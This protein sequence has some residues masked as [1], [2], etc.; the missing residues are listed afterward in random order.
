M[1][2]I[3]ADSR[4]RFWL[5]ALLALVLGSLLFRFTL[6]RF[7][8]TP[9][10][11]SLSNLTIIDAV[12]R[13]DWNAINAVPPDPLRLAEDLEDVLPQL[14]D[15]GSEIAAIL[16]SRY[17]S[18]HT[19]R[20]MLALTTS[21]HLQAAMS[22]AM[23]ISGLPHPPAVMD[24]AIT[25]PKVVD[26]MVRAQLYLAL[27]RTHDATALPAL[28]ALLATE[29]DAHASDKGIVAAAR[30]GDV[31]ARANLLLRIEGATVAN[32]KDVYDDVLYVGDVR[33]ARGLLPWLDQRDPVTRIGGDEAGRSARMCDLALW[34]AVR[35]GVKLPVSGD[36]LD[37]YDDA[38]LDR[39]RAALRQL[40]PP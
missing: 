14:D 6:S 33:F 12:R 22:A 13:G 29:R 15:E 3:S 40:T 17:P 37:I 19:A 24:I 11:A 36:S 5:T 21:T 2:V 27:G 16:A 35:L 7:T 39:A 38:M 30:L 28:L 9:E 8:H 23:A 32:A 20:F 25:T 4:R 34:T 10:G 18:Q 26:P 31:T 1:T